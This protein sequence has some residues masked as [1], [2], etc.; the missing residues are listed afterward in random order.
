ML[1][2]ILIEENITNY[3]FCYEGKEQR[4]LRG[5]DAYFGLEHFSKK[6]SCKLTCERELREAISGPGSVMGIIWILKGTK[7]ANVTRILVIC[8]YL[9][10]V[11]SESWA[12]LI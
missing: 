3:N 7:K 12:L 2:S 5:R 1:V 9:K 8:C 4:A 6:V 10:D 11:A